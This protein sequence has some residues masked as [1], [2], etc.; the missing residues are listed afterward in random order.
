[1]RA[2]APLVFGGLL[3]YHCKSDKR[4]PFGSKKLS[5]F[6]KRYFEPRG[7][8]RELAVV[9]SANDFYLSVYSRFNQLRTSLDVLRYLIK[10]AHVFPKFATRDIAIKVVADNIFNRADGYGQ[11]QDEKRIKTNDETKYSRKTERKKRADILIAA[12]IGTRQVHVSAETVKRDWARSPV[13]LSLIYTLLEAQ[14]S[15][16]DA[17]S[18]SH[19]FRCF[20]LSSMVPWGLNQIE[21]RVEHARKIVRTANPQ[22]LSGTLDI[23]TQ[24]PHIGGYLKQGVFDEAEFDFLTKYLTGVLSKKISP[25]EMALAKE[26]NLE[27]SWAWS[28]DSLELNPDW[29]EFFPP[30]D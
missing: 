6:N 23:G 24:G 18:M 15:L 22:L 8:F 10:A 28:A 30:A 21:G 3:N 26:R 13:T 1:M 25:D 7:G 11:P 27:F 16:I 19:R 9:P 17:L 5:E 12:G 14:P 20:I 4:W 2:F 29:R